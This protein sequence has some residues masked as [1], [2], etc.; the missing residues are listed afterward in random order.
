MQRRQFHAGLWSGLLGLSACGSL[1]G[2]NKTA[3]EAN[4]LD[5]MWK[6]EKR[7]NHA[8]NTVRATGLQ[9]Y[10]MM[11]GGHLAMIFYRPAGNDFVGAIAGT[12]DRLANGHV[13]E[14]Y[15]LFNFGSDQEP[16]S[17]DFEAHADAD[18]YEHVC[19][20][21]YGFSETYK[22]VRLSN[23]A[24]IPQGLWQIDDPPLNLPLRDKAQLKGVRLALGDYTIDIYNQNTFE[25]RA[26]TLGQWSK[27]GNGV[28]YTPLVQSWSRDAKD[29]A[30]A[31]IE[32]SDDEWKVEGSDGRQQRFRRLDAYESA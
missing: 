1:F 31:L 5:G 29:L 20:G 21:M 4:G 13:R 7:L 28:V 22:R 2:R 26:A 8:T 11:L 3:S 24:R 15:R 27:S 32:L 25:F 6:I 23:K 12:F 16:H 30:L 19:L 9:G 17:I 14:N 10:R 18:T